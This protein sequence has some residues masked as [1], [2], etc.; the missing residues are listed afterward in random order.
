MNPSN[1]VVLA[2][3]FGLLSG[4]SDDDP[5]VADADPTDT[6]D[7][8][9]TGDAVADVPSDVAS[10]TDATIDGSGDAADAADST[11][12][13]SLPPWAITS[14]PVAVDSPW[15]KFRRDAAQTGSTPL[16]LTDDGA[17]PWEFRTEAGIFSSPVV[18]GDGTIYVGSGDSTFHALRPDGTERWS[19]DTDGVIDSSALLDDLGRVYFGSGDGHLYALDAQTGEL[20]WRFAADAPTDGTFINWWEGNVAIGPDGTLYAGNDNFYVYAIDRETG[21]QAWRFPVNDQTWSLPAVDVDT[22]ELYVGNN[23]LIPGAG[24]VFALEPD[25]TKRWQVDTLGSVAASPLL[26]DERIVVGSFDGILRAFDT[27]DGEVLWSFPT[28]DHLYS[29]PSLHPDGFVVQA[30]ADGTIYAINPESGERVWAFD[31]GAPFRGSP[32]IDGE[33][34]IWCGSGDGHLVVLNADGTLRWALDLVED[35][36]DDLNGSVALGFHAAYLAGE[37]GSVYAVPYDFCLRPAESTNDACVVGPGERLDDDGAFLVYVDRLGNEQFTPPAEIEPNQ[38]LVFALVVREGGDNVLALVDEA[39]LAVTVTPESAFET[40]I[41]A[42]RR[43]IALVP[44]TVWTN[45]GTDPL[46]LSIRGDFLV[47]PDREGLRTE[48]GTRGGAIEVDV[49]F[50]FVEAPDTAAWAPAVPVEG[51]G[52]ATTLQ[53]RRLAAP[54]P[55]LLPSYNQI[56]FD[57]LVYQMGLVEYADGRGVVW[58]VEA[59]YDDAGVPRIIPESRGVFAF[60]LDYD[61]DVGTLTLENRDGVTLTVLNASLGFDVFRVSTVIDGAFSPLTDA[62]VQ[63]SVVCGSIPLYGTFLRRLGLCN[64]DSD[65]ISASGAVIVEPWSGGADAP[66]WGDLGATITRESDGLLATIPTGKLRASERTV[67]LLAVDEETGRPTALEYASDTAWTVDG[68][69]WLTAVSMPLPV[70]VVATPRRVYLMVGTYPAATARF[71]E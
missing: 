3:A 34:N 24:S 39:T 44:T 46:A 45:N 61:A 23:N 63:A 43:F 15:P 10:D 22:G 48:G 19:F 52:E 55:T 57:S 8:G 5:G 37:T 49:S 21:T 47:D 71:A 25:G 7:A 2:L 35:G 38:P 65:L 70:E 31:W 6:A 69:G 36:R 33:G 64:P 32:A 68:D 30:G 16:V 66:D 59:L 9:E 51:S 56:G 58:V 60:A 1:V 17:A 11:P 40:V 41:S 13:A 14:I 4:C 27:S 50:G 20:V 29:S 28:A 62:A 26:L 67:Y 18:G 12:D 42:D 53:M 54:L